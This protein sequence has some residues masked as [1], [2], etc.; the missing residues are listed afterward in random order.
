M[1]PSGTSDPTATSQAAR[2]PARARRTEAADAA[3]AKAG[4]LGFFRAQTG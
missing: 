3:P 4:L 1:P 2:K